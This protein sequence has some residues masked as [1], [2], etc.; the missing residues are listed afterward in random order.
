MA[1]RTFNQFQG[2]LEKGVVQ[3][4]AEISFGA[5]GAPTLVRGKGVASVAKASTGVYTVTLQDTYQRTLGLASTWKGSAA[6]AGDLVVLAADNV[7]TA[8]APT[9]SLKVL[10]EAG[11]ATEPASGEAVLVAVTLSNS[12]AL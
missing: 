4:F 5:S 11:V 8:N 6:P 9:L 7:A 3:L 12:T 2:S 1:N 10:D